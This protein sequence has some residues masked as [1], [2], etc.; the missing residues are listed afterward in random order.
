VRP[1]VTCESCGAKIKAGRTRCLRCGE[2][3]SA[4]EPATPPSEAPRGLSSR[5]ALVLGVSA[6][7]LAALLVVVLGVASRQPQEAETPATTT[8]VVPPLRAVAATPVQET[9]DRPSLQPV[10]AADFVRAGA[11]A[12]SEGN[13]DAALEQFE[14]AARQS[15]DDPGAQNNLGQA[16]VRV[17]RAKEALPYFA[18]ATELN[19]SDWAPRFNLAH[20]LGVL[21]EWNR[22]IMEYQKAAEIFPDDYVTLYNL[23][24]AF[25]KSGQEE[26]AVA[27]FQRA[28]ALAPGEPT[29]HLSLGI[30]Y[31]R[32]NRKDEAAQAYE[33]YLEMT[34]TAA[35]AE[36][37]RSRIE[38]LRKSV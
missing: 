34:P 17:G 20:A 4:S 13:F 30:S 2:S 33:A 1:A 8:A 10:T 35:D 29:F 6:L 11:A 25:H 16:L 36:K 26:P 27:A 19:P 18:R 21:G 12:Y 9:P 37:I 24:Q 5:G 22:A 15:P 38:A 3:L 23:G 32:L 7:S 14:Q 31:E 28:I